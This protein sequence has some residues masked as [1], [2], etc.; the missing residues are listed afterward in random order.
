[1]YGYVDQTDTQK[2]KIVI[3][4]LI[5]GIIIVV[6]IGVLISAIVKKNRVAFGGETSKVDDTAYVPSAGA[7]NAESG[8]LNP[9]SNSST[10]GTSSSDDSKNSE[11]SNNSE[12]S[13]NVV[14][15][16]SS[17]VKENTSNS[18]S[19]QTPNSTSSNKSSS[20]IPKTGATESVLGLALLLGAVSMYLLS[21]NIVLV[22]L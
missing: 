9:V 3:A 14:V 8:N 10:S 4:S 20:E 19:A 13:E 1:M 17:D 22:K 21:K 7:N 2:K 18:T 12:K 16:P 5:M 11:T 6:L 15:T